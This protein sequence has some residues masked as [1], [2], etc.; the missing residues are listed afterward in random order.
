MKNETPDNLSIIEQEPQ[1]EGEDKQRAVK[2]TQDEM[3][4]GADK[5]VD[6]RVWQQGEEGNKTE[7]GGRWVGAGA[8]K[9]EK[10]GKNDSFIKEEGGS[11][12]EVSLA[13]NEEDCDEICSAW[14]SGGSVYICGECNSWLNETYVQSTHP[15]FC[16]YCLCKKPL[17]IRGNESDDLTERD[18]ISSRDEQ[19]DREIKAVYSASPVS[20]ETS[21]EMK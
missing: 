4:A 19:G 18:D 15:F 16:K 1:E 13:E 9:E 6:V 8:G 20:S 14:F 5:M 7:G 3:A 12:E 2:E 21:S 10:E 17:R 11:H